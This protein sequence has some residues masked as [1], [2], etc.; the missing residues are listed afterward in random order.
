M[1]L[2]GPIEQYLEGKNPTHC[3]FE[4]IPKHVKAWDEDDVTRMLTNAGFL[5]ENGKPTKE[6]AQK[7]V[8]DLCG[9]KVIWNLL[10]VKKVLL[11]QEQIE[12]GQRAARNAM[13]AK[14]VDS[15]PKW[16][17]LTT[18]GTFFG[19]GAVKIGKWL[20]EI[21]MRT[22][23][24]IKKNSSGAVD[25]L[26]VAREKQAE[27]A[28]GFSGGKVPSAK[29]IDNGVARVKTVVNSKKKE[30]EITEWNLDLCKTLLVR[31]G[32]P[33]DT[34]RKLLLKG[35]GK[36]SD[37]KVKT[38]DDR[39][40]EL[41]FEWLKKSKDPVWKNNAYQVFDGQPKAVLV[42]VEALMNR[43][44]YLVNREYLKKQ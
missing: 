43:P 19:V 23:P 7:G 31:A 3:S 24:A 15:G 26:D 21:G 25:M 18:V 27:Q 22:K 12:Y 13:K 6:A 1:K 28:K 9:R 37:V 36:N 14:S 17:D 4:K 39:A 2:E 30:I 41:Y 10:E 32:H 20:D 42:R 29:A 33:L 16:V 38:I 8:V 11:S 34:E 35:K 44:G 5:N 40:K